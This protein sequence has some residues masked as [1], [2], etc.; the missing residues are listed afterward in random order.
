GYSI[1]DDVRIVG[2]DDMKYARL[3]R[4]PLTTFRQPCRQLG[5]IAVET[6]FSRLA[7]PGRNPV[8]VYAGPELITRESSRIPTAAEQ[9]SAGR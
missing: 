4:V 1:P 6:M 5:E 8:T 9:Q 2:F 3:A 7:K